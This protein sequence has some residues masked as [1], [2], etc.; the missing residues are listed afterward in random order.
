MPRINKADLRYVEDRYIDHDYLEEDE[1]E[2]D[3]EEANTYSQPEA[4]EG[5]QTRSTT[6]RR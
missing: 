1:N 2:E 3:N 5:T 6:H 4:S